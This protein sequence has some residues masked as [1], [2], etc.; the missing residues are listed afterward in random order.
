MSVL[1]SFKSERV[2]GSKGE[3]GL[4]GRR[5]LGHTSPSHE[6]FRA[7]GLVAL[8]QSLSNTE[9]DLVLLEKSM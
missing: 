2:Q 6:I 5:R 4:L 1:N 7:V 8:R 3:G 9:M